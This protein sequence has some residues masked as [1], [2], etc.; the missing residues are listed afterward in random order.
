MGI[1]FA[2]SYEFLLLDFGTIPTIQLLFGFS[3]YLNTHYFT[4]IN[5]CMVM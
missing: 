3:L 2:F 1:N 5:Q 4:W